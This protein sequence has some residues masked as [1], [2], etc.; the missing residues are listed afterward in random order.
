LCT[1]IC[2]LPTVGLIVLLS[3][4]DLQKQ[5]SVYLKLIFVYWCWNWMSCKVFLFRFNFVC[6][7]QQ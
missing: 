6:H 3:H 5:L 1:F 4:H 7:G 2:A